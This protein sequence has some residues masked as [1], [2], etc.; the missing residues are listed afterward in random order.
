MT[1]LAL[2]PGGELTADKV[3][4]ANDIPHLVDEKYAKNP[5]A[6]SKQHC[7]LRLSDVLA[8]LCKEQP[9]DQSKQ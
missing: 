8:I 4:S 9:E 2:T 1:C 3:H 7:A 5:F 6:T